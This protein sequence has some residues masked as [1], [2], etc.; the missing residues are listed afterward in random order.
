MQEITLL[1][2]IDRMEADFMRQFK[3]YLQQVIYLPQVHGYQQIS[4]LQFWAPGRL[5]KILTP[6]I[7]D[8]FAMGRAHG[9]ILCQQLIKKYDKKNLAVWVPSVESDVIKLAVG[10]D[11]ANFWLHPTEAIAALDAKELILAGD[12]EAD[13]LSDVKSILL[14]HM[15]QGLTTAATNAM[16]AEA[17]NATYKRGQLICTTETT[18][19]YNRGRLASY[20][21]NDVDYVQFSAVMDM[22]TSTQCKSR[23]G[24]VMRMDSPQLASN[25]PPL[26]GRCRSVLSPMYS[27]YEPSKITQQTT[28]WSQ[29][30]PLP[31]GWRMDGN[32]SIAKEPQS[33]K[34]KEKPS[35]K[36]NP[37]D[38]INAEEKRIAGKKT[39]TAIL[40][41]GQGRVVF[42]KGGDESSVNFTNQEAAK[43]RGNILTHNHPNNSSFSAE[44]ILCMRITS[45][46]EIRAVTLDGVFIAKSPGRWLPFTKDEYLKAYKE[47]R[48]AYMNYYRDKIRDGEMDQKKAWIAH[49]DRVNKGL[50]KRFGFEYKF[51][52]W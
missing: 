20:A 49:S 52:K 33:S 41:D 8:M 27:K 14:N 36:T 38:Y 44:D 4:S 6:Y 5:G 25:T 1:K 37:Y 32:K 12:I 42:S 51:E 15:N 10:Y 28:D 3:Q 48:D 31:K 21:A 30:S 34:I 47:E 9:D 24:L 13:I 7:R 11:S 18:Y 17:L 35:I 22:R 40:F 43:M 19:A 29:V 2:R 26:H 16:I 46:K 39:E 50:A 23:H 45:L